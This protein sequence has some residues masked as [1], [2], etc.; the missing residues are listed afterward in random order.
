MRKIKGISRDTLRFILEVSRSSY[1]NE[2]A[3]LLQAEDGIIIDVLILPGTESGKSSAL[4]RLYMM[5]NISTVGSVHSHP[6][7]SIK[8]SSADLQMFGRTGNYHI[9]AGYPYDLQSWACFNAKGEEQELQIID[10]RA[11]E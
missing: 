6:G 2:F 10:D 11:D 4:L 8:P 1:P 3:G 9:I 7:G 5:P